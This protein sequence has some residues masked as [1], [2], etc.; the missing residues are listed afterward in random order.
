MLNPTCIYRSSPLCLAGYLQ[1]HVFVS[2]TLRGTTSEPHPSSQVWT[3]VISNAVVRSSN[4]GHGMMPEMRSNKLKIVCV[5]SK[6]VN[7]EVA[8]E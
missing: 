1:K 5:D 2:R 6:L 8:T 4:M 7:P 3:F